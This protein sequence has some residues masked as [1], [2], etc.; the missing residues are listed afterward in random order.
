ME[1]AVVERVKNRL[2][3]SEIIQ[4]KIAHLLSSEIT[5]TLHPLYVPVG[6]I[7]DLSEVFEN[8]AAQQLIR[9]EQ[10]ENKPTKRVTQIAFRIS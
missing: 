6:I 1:T 8:P 10:Q 9:E 7:K 2:V 3:L 5:E 4:E